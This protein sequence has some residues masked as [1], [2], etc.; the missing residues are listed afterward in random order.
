MWDVQVDAPLDEQN[1]GVAAEAV[2]ELFRGSQVLCVSHH[3]PFHSRADTII[4]V[5]FS[6]FQTA[7][8]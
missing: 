1:Q 3:A 6:I 7:S 5:C 4:Q 8:L 2:A